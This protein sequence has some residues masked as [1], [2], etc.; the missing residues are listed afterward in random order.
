MKALKHLFHA[1]N[2]AGLAPALFYIAPNIGL[3]PVLVPVITGILSH[4][5][6]VAV[7]AN[8]SATTPMVPDKKD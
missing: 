5:I 8:I 2:W 1:I 4:V 3:P 7:P 6:N